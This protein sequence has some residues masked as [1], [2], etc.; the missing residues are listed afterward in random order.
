[1]K[2]IDIKKLPKKCSK[3]LYNKRG[4]SL[5][6]LSLDELIQMYSVIVVDNCVYYDKNKDGAYERV[7]LI[8]NSSLVCSF[9]TTMP[10]A[11]IK[12]GIIIKNR[13]G[14]I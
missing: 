10:D 2:N 6:S 4:I 8:N 9:G 11:V 12:N 3:L 7:E 5:E 13:Y 14:D 1:M